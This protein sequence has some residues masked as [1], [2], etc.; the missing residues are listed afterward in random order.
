MSSSI[1]LVFGDDEF[2]VSSKAKELIASAIAPE[3]Q[4]LGL[5]T[6][7]AK[8][9]TV[10]AALA[11]LDQAI[12]SVRTPGFMGSD[13][14]I[15][16]RDV[17]FL[18]DSLVGK[19][20]AV[21]DRLGELTDLIKHGLLPGQHLLVTAP[22]VDKRCAFYK[23][24]KQYGSI[25]EFSIPDRD[26]EAD[27]QAA[28]FLR[29]AVS[30]KGLKMSRDVLLAFVE[31][32]GT[33]TRQLL[34]ELDKLDV[35][36]GDRREAGIEDIRTITCS[37]REAI[38][39]D[40]TDAVAKRD[41]AGSLEM[42]RQLS[43]QKQSPIGLIIM[44]GNRI[45]EL[46]VYR[47]AINRRWLVRRKGQR[48]KSTVAWGNLP[49]EAETM[50]EQWLAKDP[51]KTHFYRVGLLAEQANLFSA[52]DLERCHREIV[53]AH[54]TLVSTGIPGLLVLELLVL[55]MLA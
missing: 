4:A 23:A 41:L 37:S 39:W 15:W 7:E 27:R 21:K 46:M 1:H 42:V 17:N 10:D 36:L 43:F 34:C 13:K 49:P 44:M 25:Q 26:Y 6:V 11:R 31:R 35:Y 40:L 33:N 30:E 19:S 20:K 29:Q 47:E 28:T 14:M 18:W 12:E 22:K 45:R 9:D 48:G 50:F 5:E 55:K 52:A 32:V 8:A 54:E 3:N 24:C 38:I 2:H 53:A 51:R 16:L